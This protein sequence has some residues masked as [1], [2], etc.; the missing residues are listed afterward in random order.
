MSPHST[1]EIADQ[2]TQPG[3]AG[4]HA[5]NTGETESNATNSATGDD[6]FCSVNS[7]E[8]V[9]RM[10][11]APRI[12]LKEGKDDETMSEQAGKNANHDVQDTTSS[13]ET[14]RNPHQAEDI[15]DKTE[16]G[17][18]QSSID[19][20][21]EQDVAKAPWLISALNRTGTRGFYLDTPIGRKFIHARRAKKPNKPTHMFRARFPLSDPNEEL[22]DED[23]F[24][25]EERL[26]DD[27]YEEF[28][29]NWREELRA[30]KFTAGIR[31]WV[32]DCG[33]EGMWDI[34]PTLFHALF[35]TR[36]ESLH[37]GR[38]P[39]GKPFVKQCRSRTLRLLWTIAIYK[40]TKTERSEDMVLANLIVL[41]TVIDHPG[42]VADLPD[43]PEAL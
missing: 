4:Y 42:Q 23:E 21:D 12:P 31:N 6:F 18:E 29:Q 32:R 15:T 38:T 14:E 35:G 5:L 34:S 24:P 27:D 3:I 40:G 17:A 37:F 39:E 30:V 2:S 8:D 22:W 41:S 19:A 13:S 43:P 26:D 36:R 10:P 1:T 11:T 25:N 16:K 33:S 28:V 9:A 7:D 20:G